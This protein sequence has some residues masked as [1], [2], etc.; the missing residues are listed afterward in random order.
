MELYVILLA[1]AAQLGNTALL[2][3]IEIAPFF[4]QD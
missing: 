2:F 4:A 3:G 1:R